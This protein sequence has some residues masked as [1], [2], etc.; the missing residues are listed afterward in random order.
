MPYTPPSQLSPTTSKQNS[1]APSRSQSYVTGPFS[2]E[3]PSSSTI[4]NLPR[5]SG[6][7]SY[8]SM[9]RRSPSLSDVKDVLHNGEMYE[10]DE[11][12]VFDPHGSIR[13]SPPPVSNS[14][15]PAGM[16]VSPPDSHNSSDDED[17]RGR[18]RDLEEDNLKELQAA[19]RIIGL[20]KEGSPDRS[21]DES[22]KTHLAM[23]LVAHP[24]TADPPSPPHRSESP[25]PPLSREARKIS[26]SRSSTDSSIVFDSPQTRPAARPR[27]PAHL[28]PHDSDDSDD[29]DSST[30]T[31]LR[32]PMVRKKS[33]E[34][35]RPALRAS[36]RRRPSSMP[37]TPTYTKAVH[38]DA[39]LEHVRHFLQVDRPLAVSAG[40]SPVE[41]YESESEFPFSPSDEGSSRSRSPPF[42]WEMRLANFPPESD[43]RKAMPVHVERVFLSSDKK[44]L[45]GTVAVH[46]LA[47]QKLVV[48]RFT[49]DYW[50]TTSEVTAD[51]T[52]DVRR[53]QQQ[54]GL[55]RFT[56]SISLAD[57]A[58]L[59]NKTLFFCI[60]YVV[61][62]QEYWDNN[63]GVNYQVDF[64]KKQ[65]PQP[66]SANGAMSG[67]GA[68]PLNALPRSRPSSATTS[69]GRPHS[70]PVSLDDFSSGFD[71]LGPFGAPSAGALMGE[72]RLKLRSP[73]SKAELVTE[74]PAGRRPRSS[75]QAFGNR[76]DFDSSLSAAK[77]HAVAALG[78]QSGLSSRSDTK[79]SSSNEVP[80]ATASKS[81]T[82][83][84]PK[85]EMGVGGAKAGPTSRSPAFA[86][87][88][89][90]PAALVSEKL[91]LTSQSYQELVDKY[92]F[93]GTRGKSDEIGTQ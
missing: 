47:F 64:S 15:I 81:L 85:H 92:C 48:T 30:T 55:D 52:H 46:N 62:G 53:K 28:L 19:I 51:Y 26:H 89:S 29:S 27:S 43:A 91:P 34:L 41:N 76:Y 24:P 57:Q 77:S 67:L 45:I 31:T 12:R 87:M 14:L 37:G 72:P 18:M 44:N 79:Q 35:V 49:L 71:D 33:G 2:P 23:D 39:H 8:L 1:P 32:P 59:E 90:K 21:Q 80:A 68:R 61:D 10:E 16:T 5:S 93:V 66:P 42:E 4:P 50:K 70:M 69:L 65:R 86:P 20:S 3:I 78:E 38:F 88:T 9:H 83:A 7:S 54:D 11:E 60:R 84:P 36:S 73:R 63:G 75:G 6:S 25:R 56:F 17:V 82:P 74:A 22:S 58:N 13:P 40:S